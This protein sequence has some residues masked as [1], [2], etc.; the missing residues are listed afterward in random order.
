MKCIRYILYLWGRKIKLAKII[1][2]WRDRPDNW[3]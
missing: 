3:K 2:D 1:V